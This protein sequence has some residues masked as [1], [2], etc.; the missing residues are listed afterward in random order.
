[1]NRL[2]EP[3]SIPDRKELLVNRSGLTKSILILAIL[4]LLSA[5]AFSAGGLSNARDWFP[6]WGGTEP[7]PSPAPSA[8]ASP[9]QPAVAPV[10][11]T[12]GALPSLAPIA[13]AAKPA[14]VN[15]STTQTVKG[16]GG[17]GFG[18]FMGPFG[19]NDP[20]EEF[21]HRFAPEMPK[22][23]KQRS[24]GSGFVIGADGTIV[25]NHHVVDGADEI[26]VRLS[27][28]HHKYKAKVLGSD[29]KT[30]LAILKIE[31]EGKLPT[32]ALGDSSR[33]RVGDWV[34]AIG[35]PFGLEQTVTAGIVSATGRVIG[36]GPYDDFIQ[37]DASINPGNS[38]GPLLNV[39][40]EVVGINSAIFSQS[41][42]NV[43]IG[44]AIPSKLASSVVEQL[45]THGK[46][47][48]GW[49]GVGI[50]DVTDELAQSFGI[51]QARGALV[52]EVKKDGPGAR[53]GLEQGDV[54]LSYEGHAIEASHEL[55]GLV[56][57]TLVGKEVEIQVL[58]NGKE[59]TLTAKVGEMPKEAGQEEGAEETAAPAE[60]LGL[61]IEPITPEVAR[62]LGLSSDA[63]VLVKAVQSGSVAEDAGLRPGDVI[64]EVDRKAVKSVSEF[65]RIVAASKEKKAL[66]FLVRRGDAT[67]FLALKKS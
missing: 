21:F 27:S 59:R 2:G 24:L 3:P 1:M 62:S 50:Q 35:N 58:R 23:F 29:P 28:S 67:L 60:K 32:L 66:L 36:Q 26:I 57:A 17:P 19:G 16:H 42:G 13:A 37:T 31:P 8:P 10:S 38:G 41:G 61:L 43:G 54:I 56:A 63:G 25:T 30:D 18:P 51:S 48:R 34:I 44:F 11:S 53:A 45:K 47:V 12:Q 5:G 14:V 39:E 40:G 49:L 64:L 33:L 15:I 65:K 46:V 52:A 7:T 55:P 4:L 9:P 22:T 20:F 6:P